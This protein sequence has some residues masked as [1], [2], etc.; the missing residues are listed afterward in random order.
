MDELVLL[1]FQLGCKLEEEEEA[2]DSG[3]NLR[4]D[5]TYFRDFVGTA[6]AVCR[7]W[8]RL[9]DSHLS[10][11]SRFRFTSA[12]LYDDIGSE[13]SLNKGVQSFSRI[14]EQSCSLKSDLH[15]YLPLFILGKDE[16]NPES[17]MPL[18]TRLFRTWNLLIPHRDRLRRL[19][20]SVDDPEGV[21]FV[22]EQLR[23]FLPGTTPNLVSLQIRDMQWVKYYDPH[24]PPRIVEL[25]KEFL[26]EEVKQES[27]EQFQAIQ[28]LDSLRELD[29]T[30]FYI[31]SG[32]KP[33]PSL[34]VLKIHVAQCDSTDLSSPSVLANQISEFLRGCPSL[35]RM[36]L[37]WREW[38]DAFADEPS[39]MDTLSA[40]PV[41]SLT[42][43]HLD[44]D[45]VS[46]YVLGRK[47][48]LPSLIDLQVCLV[49]S[50]SLDEQPF[51]G[52]SEDM[53]K[54]PSFPS[55]QSLRVHNLTDTCFFRMLDAPNL[56]SL[57]VHFQAVKED[58]EPRDVCEASLPALSKLRL[59]T[60]KIFPT[61]PFTAASLLA[62]IDCSKIENL[63][64][65][66]HPPNT[67]NSALNSTRLSVPALKSLT[68][69]SLPNVTADWTL[70]SVTD[71]QELT[72]MCIWEKDR[73]TF[74]PKPADIPRSLLSIRKL[75]LLG[76]GV[77]E[78]GIPLENLSAFP[79]LETLSIMHADDNLLA[80]IINELTPTSAEEQRP[81]VAPHLNHLIVQCIEP[82]TP[83]HELPPP[84]ST[85][86]ATMIQKRLS[87][88]CSALERITFECGPWEKEGGEHRTQRAHTSSLIYST[89][90][91]LLEFKHEFGKRHGHDRWACFCMQR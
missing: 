50:S 41:P 64:C 79:L 6:R 23:R 45:I 16:E 73:A 70:S 29:I 30:R 90:G 71:L 22:L 5:G 62:A 59:K 49:R 63:W 33:P 56:H 77:P 48:N 44:I 88:G 31:I 91:E 86:L 20:V 40:I 87:A 25:P 27:I 61:S 2:L 47:L 53:A 14:L 69:Q 75:L 13:E 78:N 38:M 19:K 12:R 18:L 52:Y 80:M 8:K 34:R 46:F 39:E 83:E 3:L 72:I 35:D 82:L 36:E 43:L 68:T 76:L 66:S 65:T 81:L 7:H 9:V 85:Q 32:M 74:L 60:L 67:D 10:T 15:V 17:Y 28:H 26:G 89:T 24:R 21:R 84:L 57:Q 54:P 11:K 4:Y 55:L 42:A 58:E 51:H 1:I 37:V